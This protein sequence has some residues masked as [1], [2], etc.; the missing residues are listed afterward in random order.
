MVSGSV[1]RRVVFGYWA[2]S[3]EDTTEFP[4]PVASIAPD[5]EFLE[6]VARVEAEACREVRYRGS[7]LSRL[8][9]KILGCKEFSLSDPSTGAEVCWPGDYASHYLAAGVPPDPRF[10]AFIEQ[11]YAA[12]PSPGRSP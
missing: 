11:A 5:Q 4:W 7:S 3:P 10:V 6:R 8:T 12:L 1:D 9:G 2:S